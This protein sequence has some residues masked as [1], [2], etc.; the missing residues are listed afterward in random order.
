L[1]DKTKAPAGTPPFQ[2][3][4]RHSIS[5]FS[6]RS[7]SNRAGYIH[8]IASETSQT[9]EIAEYSSRPDFAGCCFAKQDNGTARR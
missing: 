7:P 5:S 1:G 6:T 3:A 9:P 2:L 4:R 8:L